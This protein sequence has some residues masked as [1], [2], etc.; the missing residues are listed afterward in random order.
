VYLCWPE[1]ALLAKAALIRLVVESLIA[2]MNDTYDNARGRNCRPVLLLLDEAG[3]VG[4]PNLARYAATVAGRGMSLWV[5][6]QEF[7]QLED[8]YGRYK[9]R[10]IRTRVL[11]I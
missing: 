5:A 8:L 7:A 2:E 11:P 10:T 6:I 3:T 9:A 1:G 4:I